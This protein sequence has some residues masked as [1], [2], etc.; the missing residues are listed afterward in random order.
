M[1]PIDLFEQVRE[2]ATLV[3]PK[4]PAEIPR[5]FVLGVRAGIA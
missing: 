1:R 3:D 5:Q 4:C 2:A